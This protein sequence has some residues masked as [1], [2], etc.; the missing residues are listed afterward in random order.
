MLL[1]KEAVSGRSQSDI[2]G[3]S[4]HM[5]QR[6]QIAISFGAGTGRGGGES[7]KEGQR[8]EVC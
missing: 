5:N 4:H 8:W 2:R 1:V 7:S 6:L 3:S